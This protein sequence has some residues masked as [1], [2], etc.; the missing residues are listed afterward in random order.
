MCIRDRPTSICPGDPY[1]PNDTFDAA[2]GPFPLNQDFSG[3]FKCTTDLR[4]YYRFGLAQPRTLV[5]TLRS[6][7]PGSGY[8]T[9]LYA[10]SGSKLGE[11][12]VAQPNQS[13]TFEVEA[14]GQ[15]GYYAL[16]VVRPAA[17][18]NYN[19]PYVLRMTDRGP[20]EPNNSF[21]QAGSC[22]LTSKVAHFAFIESAQDVNDYYSLQMLAAHTIN[23]ELTSLPANTN[24]D[25]FLYDGNRT[26][27]YRAATSSPTEIIQTTT[28][29]AGNYYVRVKQ[30]S[31]FSNSDTYL[32]KALFLS[33]IHISEPT[34]PY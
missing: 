5:V 20:C 24:F 12:T 26:E 2:W 28:L 29:P 3:Y 21:D 16:R 8:Q 6:I 25:L 23:I 32:L 15:A 27:L 30:T 1:E 22:G 4:D 10:S 31:G 33:L 17:S 14:P 9:A 34:R 19:N 7:P 11:E 13:E 18:P